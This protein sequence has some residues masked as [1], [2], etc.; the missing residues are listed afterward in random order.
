MDKWLNSLIQLM[1]FDRARGIALGCCRYCTRFGVGI[2]LGLKNPCRHCTRSAVGIALGFSL[3]PSALLPLWP[4]GVRGI[5]NAIVRSALFNVASLREG[6]AG[7][8]VRAFTWKDEATGKARR[9]WSVLLEPRIAALFDPAC[10]SR[11]DWQLRMQ[12]PPL[13]KF[14]HTFHRTHTLPFAYKVETL[15]GQPLLTRQCN[16]SGCFAIDLIAIATGRPPHAFLSFIGLCCHCVTMD[17]SPGG[18]CRCI[19]A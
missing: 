3:M 10:Y 4:N 5:P 6:Y 12:L 2:E 15:K 8:L 13:A 7:S 11:L 9:K 16:A 14:L 19:A 1:F 18:A 17:P